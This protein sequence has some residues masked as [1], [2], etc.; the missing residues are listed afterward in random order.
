MEVQVLS[1]APTYR[2]GMTFPIET[3]E[4]HQILPSLRKTISDII[5]KSIS[6]E[7]PYIIHMLGVPGSGKSTVMKEI[8]NTLKRRPA[9]VVGFDRLM[10]TIPEYHQGSDRQKSFS[11]FELPARAAGYVLIKELLQ[12]QSDILFDHGGASA[13][14]AD[15]LSFAKSKGYTVAV[16][17]VTAHP[18]IAKK[19][20]LERQLAEGRHTP[21]S[22]VDERIKII[23]NILPSYKTTADYFFEI[24]NEQDI[25]NSTAHLKNA[26]DK[27]CECIDS[28]I[29]Q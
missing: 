24:S 8:W 19:R 1:P 18:D 28:K 10:E 22:Y 27:I 15:L 20:I 17:Q 13:A 14:H 2:T 21:P 5:E 23:E 6:Q 16:I 12:K 11:E 26:A 29:S 7:K 9:A 4:Y 3:L 25:L